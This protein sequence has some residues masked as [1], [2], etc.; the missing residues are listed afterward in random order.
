MSAEFDERLEDENATAGGGDPTSSA[1]A[2]GLIEGG[3]R[4]DRVPGSC[5]N[6]W[7]A[8]VVR[9]PPPVSQRGSFDDP[10]PATVFE[11]PAFSGEDARFRFARNRQNT[12]PEVGTNP[13]DIW[14]ESVE[15]TAQKDEGSGSEPYR[16]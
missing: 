12:E 4:A 6:R 9:G 11:R 3:E 10:A 8:E 14:G 1:L 13:S 7:T 5:W 2:P 15:R 16:K